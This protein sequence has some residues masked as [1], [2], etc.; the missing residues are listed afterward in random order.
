M[1]H[2]ELPTREYKKVVIEDHSFIVILVLVLEGKYTC[3]L[4]K[5]PNQ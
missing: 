2:E 3:K 1:F 4:I 5:I